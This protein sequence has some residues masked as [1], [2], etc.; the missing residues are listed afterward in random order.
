MVGDDESGGVW[1][2]VVFAD[3]GEEKESSSE[4]DLEIAKSLC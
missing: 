4:F 2:M 1:S 3:D